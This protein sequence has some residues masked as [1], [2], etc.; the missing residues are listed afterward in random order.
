[1]G[2]KR[3]AVATGRR[4]FTKQGTDVWTPKES[5]GP[6]LLPMLGSSPAKE[7][8]VTLHGLRFGFRLLNK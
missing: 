5:Q 4:K 6:A 3:P 8:E 1:M 2:N 7:D